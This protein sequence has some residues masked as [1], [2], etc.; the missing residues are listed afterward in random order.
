MNTTTTP[1][2]GFEPV[3]RVTP[4]VYLIA[5]FDDAVSDDSTDILVSVK[6]D[7]VRVVVNVDTSE[8]ET[9]LYTGENLE[10]LLSVCKDAR[11]N[12]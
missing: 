4:S 3:Q 11:D 2:Y 5:R 10:N 8:I 9:H 7:Q 12:L 6:D 1:V